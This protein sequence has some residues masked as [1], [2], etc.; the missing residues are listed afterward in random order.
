MQLHRVATY[1]D[2]SFRDLCFVTDKTYRLTQQ[3]AIKEGLIAMAIDVESAQDIDST[4]VE[5]QH[6]I[7]QHNISF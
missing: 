3:K 7:L 5:H 2:S 6:Y 4:T 1:L